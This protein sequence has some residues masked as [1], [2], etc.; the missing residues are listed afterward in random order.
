MKARCPACQKTAQLPDSE[1]GMMAVC[2]ACGTTYRL[3]LAPPPEPAA[4]AGRAVEPPPDPE[5]VQ[6]GLRPT[7]IAFWGIAGAAGCVVAL[8]VTWGVL[9][10]RA[11]R[12]DARALARVTRPAM[13]VPTTTPTTAPAHQTVT[14]KV[15]K[16]ERKSVVF[17][18]TRPGAR[19]PESRPSERAVVASA[20]ERHLP[21]MPPLPAPAPRPPAPTAAPGSQPPHVQASSRPPVRP[22]AV[23]SRDLTDQQI[24]QAIHKGASYLLHRFDARTHLLAIDPREGGVTINMINGR[25]VI[26]PSIPPQIAGEDILCVYALLQCGEAID[27]PRLNYRESPMKD[28]I[29]S[30]KSIPL[31]NYHYE[32]Y[33][34]ALR[35]TALAL[36]NQP[37]DRTALKMDAMAL[38][39]GSHSGAYTYTDTPAPGHSA[40]ELERPWDNSNSQ[41]GL[42][43]VW[44]AAE[45]GFEVSDVYWGAVQ[46]HWTQTQFGNGQWSYNMPF[47]TGT[48]SMTCAGLASLLVTY[49]YLEA[50]RFGTS[51]GRDPFSPAI[52]RG[53]RWLEQGNNCLELNHGGYNLYGLERV[54]LAS[55]FKYFGTHDWYRELAARS[56]EAQDTDGSWGQDVETAY[57]LLFLARGRHPIL[58]NKLRFDG[59]WANRPR[60]AANLARFAARQLERPLNWQVV[61]LQRDWTAWN[62]SPILYLASHEPVKLSDDD[63]ARIRTFVD[64]G[65]LLFTQADGDSLAF[66]SF[67]VQLAHRLFGDYELTDLPADHPLFSTMFKVRPD[68]PLKYVTNGSRILMLHSN[69]DLA[70]YWQLRDDKHMPFPFEFGTDLFVYAAGKRDLRNR[71]ESNYIPPVKVAPTATIKVARLSYPGNWNPEPAAWTRFSRW[72]QLQTGYG[73]DVVECPMR[74]LS[75][76]T[77]P[78][79]HLTG[80]AAYSPTALEVA[81]VK[82]YVESG[83]VLVVDLCGGT[84]A[85]DKQLQSDLFRKAF[86]DVRTEVMSPSHPLLSASRDGMEDLSRPHLRQFA[87]DAL[88]TRGGYPE[89]IAAGKG[90]VIFSSL[91]ITTGLL[92]TNTWGILGYDPNYAQ[93]L[94]KNI[95]LWTWDGQQ[96]EQKVARSQS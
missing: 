78:I 93:S 49:D 51:V 34:R 40:L 72:F 48:H 65:G 38:V 1:A 41:Y 71:L 90:H 37:Q 2:T 70:K 9:Q 22:V 28:M 69:T 81:A 94:L 14:S 19:P 11:S 66:D 33:A 87:T 54:A 56:I 83:G 29:A 57:N 62:D 82:R 63:V 26:S 42:L 91:D 16:Q 75:P 43:G 79:A 68:V 36:H 30:M 92:G 73:V 10:W 88:G 86:P 4:D 61:P 7:V 35:A 47:A 50:P 84:G 89:E 25:R 76:R 46:N 8:L 96:D 20:T 53:L 6:G 5:P 85:F 95:I 77:A 18:S 52:R 59:Y 3:P 74:E 31:E 24:G 39:R 32:T 60:D 21:A 80:T 27:D 58:M 15:R 67:A 17:S 23:E 45:T 55:G 64:N 12:P 44:S 13:A